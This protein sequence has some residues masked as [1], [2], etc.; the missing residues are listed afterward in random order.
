MGCHVKI[1]NIKRFVRVE[2]NI[3]PSLRMAHSVPTATSTCSGGDN[4]TIG[5]LPEGTTPVPAI[6][7][8]LRM[9]SVPGKSPSPDPLLPGTCDTG[10]GL[11]DFGGGTKSQGRGT[12]AAGMI[13]V[14]NS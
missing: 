14:G 6:F 5:V 1:V 12:R 8:G 9:I 2:G 13:L 7:E 4:V 3:K 11:V 10:L